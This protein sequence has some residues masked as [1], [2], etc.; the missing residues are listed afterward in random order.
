MTAPGRF[1]A[2]ALLSGAAL[3]LHQLRYLLAYGGHSGEQ[4]AVQAHAYLA[5]V[6]PLAVALVFLAFVGFSLSLLGAGRGASPRSKLPRARAMWARSSGALLAVYSV[7]EWL[8]G[9]LGQ[10]HSSGLGAIFAN[11]GWWAVPL[12]FVLGA[13]VAW[14]LKGAA[15]A[16]EFVAARSHRSR[17]PRSGSRARGEH[18]SQR[19]AL[20]VVASFLAGR[21]PPVTSS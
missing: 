8:E 12:A 10:G 20:D 17:V 16:I 3:M 4:L 19:P 6:L 18:G 13:L 11:G 5:L 15:T 7:Q 1:R 21:G 14:L 2:F 9:Q